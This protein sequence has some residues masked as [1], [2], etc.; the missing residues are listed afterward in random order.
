MTTPDVKL[1]VDNPYRSCVITFD[2]KRIGQIVK[3]FVT[4]AIKNTRKGYVK[5]GYRYAEGTGLTITVEDTGIG[6]SKENYGHVFK[7]FEKIDNFAQG[8][9]LELAIVKAF[10][11]HTGNE[12]GFTSCEGRGSIFYFVVHCT[13]SVEERGSGVMPL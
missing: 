9:G 5:M 3:I 6:I 11:D 12:V 7:R 8:S 1:I 10:A 2:E 4:N 13:A